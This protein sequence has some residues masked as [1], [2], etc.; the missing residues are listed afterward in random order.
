MM[1]LMILLYTLISVLS[2]YDDFSRLSPCK[3]NMV[4]DVKGPHPTSSYLMD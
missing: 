4:K 3:S 1:L 2:I